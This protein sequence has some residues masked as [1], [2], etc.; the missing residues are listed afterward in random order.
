MLRWRDTSVPGLQAKKGEN[1]E[2][3]QWRRKGPDGSVQYPGR[4]E[5]I[6]V[7]F[8]YAPIASAHRIGPLIRK[9][10]S[11]EGY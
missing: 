1:R 2:G 5:N 9:Q 10:G 3:F 6:A 8:A 4:Q 7:K 11:T